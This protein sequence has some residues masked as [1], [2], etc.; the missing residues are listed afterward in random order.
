[1][2]QQGLA[3][4]KPPLFTRDNYAYWSVIMTS[5]L[6]AFGYK[7]CSNFETKY[8]LL[9]DVP[10]DEGDLKLYEANAKYLNAILSGLIGIRTYKSH[11]M[12]KKAKCA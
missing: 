4:N 8:K 7:A 10:I 6:M 5:H 12:Q 9:D 1:M 11:A 3:T 2:D